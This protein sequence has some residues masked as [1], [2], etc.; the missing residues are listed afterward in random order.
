MAG[1]GD[2]SFELCGR[3]CGLLFIH[4]GRPFRV[5]QPHELHE[6][7]LHPGRGLSR[8]DGEA[9]LP[10]A[11]RLGVDRDAQRRL[12]SRP[13]RQRARLHGYLSESLD[14]DRD[15]LFHRE[16]SSGRSARPSDLSAAI[17][18]LGRHGDMV[19]RTE[20]LQGCA[21]SSGKPITNLSL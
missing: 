16:P 6:R 15:Q 12:R 3:R 2:T 4:G 8:A 17:G 5:R 10:E 18:A 11:V 7:V 14:E 20:T 21:L 1:I 19:P 13:D 9:H